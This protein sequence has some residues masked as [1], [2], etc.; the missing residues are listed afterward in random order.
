MDCS[1]DTDAKCLSFGSQHQI[2][3]E[4]GYCTAIL[5]DKSVVNLSTDIMYR[6][7]GQEQMLFMQPSLLTDLE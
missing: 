4:S 2:P 6:E 7:D 5:A 1:E 3:M